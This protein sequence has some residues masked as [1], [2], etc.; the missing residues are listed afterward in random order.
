MSVYWPGTNIVKSENN[1]FTGW[2]KEGQRH[3]K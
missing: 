2:K 3:D 1:A